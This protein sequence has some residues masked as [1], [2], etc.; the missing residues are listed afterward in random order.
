MNWDTVHI[1]LLAPFGYDWRGSHFL[2]D[3]TK[4]RLIFELQNIL[5]ENFV[6]LTTLN[7]SGGVS[8]AKTNVAG[9]DVHLTR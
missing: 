7:V 9:I 3:T 4:I 5:R 8:H 6:N 2:I 1:S